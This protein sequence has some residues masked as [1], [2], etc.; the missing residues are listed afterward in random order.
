MWITQLCL[1]KSALANTDALWGQVVIR[2]DGHGRV[3][4]Q[5]LKEKEV[6]SVADMI[7]SFSGFSLRERAA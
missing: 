6:S 7:S 4:A 2:E 5:G 3:V 1:R